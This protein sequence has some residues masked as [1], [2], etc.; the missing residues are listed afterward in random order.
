MKTTLAV[1][2]AV[3]AG[4]LA[5]CESTGVSSRIQEKPAV[6]AGLTADQQKMIESGE[7][8]VGFTS[9]MVY[10]ALGKP[11]RVNTKDTPDGPVTMWTYTKYFPTNTTVKMTMSRDGGMTYAPPMV[12]AN[13]PTGANAPAM[14]RAPSFGSAGTGPQQSLEPGDLPTDTLYVMIYNDKVFQ[15]KLESQG[16]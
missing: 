4:L 10:L 11:A 7:I 5:G 12:S 13:A 9:D 16:G 15:I 1:I 6:F 8:E 14:F 3:T 2:C